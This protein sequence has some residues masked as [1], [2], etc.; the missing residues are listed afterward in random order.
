MEKSDG[1]L[2]SWNHHMKRFST[3]WLYY[4]M[5]TSNRGHGSEIIN[6]MKIIHLHKGHTSEIIKHEKD[7]H[8][9]KRIAIT[10][11]YY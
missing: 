4:T 6:M 10:V 3:S 7:L 5:E 8:P 11:Q 9:L 2:G 1:K